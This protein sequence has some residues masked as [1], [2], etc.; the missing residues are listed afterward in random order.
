[1]YVAQKR[2]KTV[3][4]WFT[5]SSVEEVVYCIN[6]V[7]I[8]NAEVDASLTGVRLENHFLLW[9]PS[10]THL[11]RETLS[12]IQMQLPEKDLMMNSHM[13]RWEQKIT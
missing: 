9:L 5:N 3:E 12:S 8:I 1:M 7:V 2:H 4:V 11:C 13:I 10:F 6:L